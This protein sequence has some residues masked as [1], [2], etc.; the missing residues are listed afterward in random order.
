M[1]K[2]LFFILLILS[3]NGFSQ[4]KISNGFTQEKPDWEWK[5]NQP[6]GPFFPQSFPLFPSN[7]TSTQNTY[8]EINWTRNNLRKFATNNMKLGFNDEN[9]KDGDNYAIDVFKT[10]FGKT[11]ESISIKYNTF[12]FY[13]LPVVKSIEITGNKRLLI[14]FFVKIYDVKY[15]MGNVKNKK[16]QNN[17]L[18]DDIVL[19]LN[20]PNI[21]ITNNQ[22]K[23]KEEFAVYF[24]ELLQY[25]KRGKE[26]PVSRI[27]Y[28]KKQLILDK[29]F[30]IKNDSIKKV[31]LDPSFVNDF[32][33][34]LE[35]YESFVFPDFKG[36][37][38]L[39]FEISFAITPKREFFITGVNE[40][41]GDNLL[42]ANDLELDAMSALLRAAKRYKA[43]ELDELNGK[44]I[45][46]CRM[47]P[48]YI[49]KR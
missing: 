17:F 48:V 47:I 37:D 41:L 22:F 3:I 30:C 29:G 20:K 23:T 44:E 43:K 36:K 13:G 19:D 38:T 26:E 40:K 32:M 12:I 34:N 6:I 33:G 42:N 2:I 14:D 45:N 5:V 35:E 16:F 8:Y 25:Y 27:D 39:K 11:I 7:Y 4:N 49:K 31:K 1:K 9:S 21:L 15:D 10:K 24:D 28:F 46:T 18:Q